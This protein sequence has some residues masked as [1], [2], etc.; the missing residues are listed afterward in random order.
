MIKGN[1]ACT[2]NCL[3]HRKRSVNVSNHYVE[4]C[5]NLSFRL[6]ALFYSS[7]PNSGPLHLSACNS[8]FCCSLVKAFDVCFSSCRKSA[9]KVWKSLKSLQGSNHLPHQTCDSNQGKWPVFHFHESDTWDRLHN[10]WSPVQNENVGLP[11]QNVLRI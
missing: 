1:N 11:V 4:S 9:L 2:P 5:K 10:V 3:E 7:A 6:F 8:W